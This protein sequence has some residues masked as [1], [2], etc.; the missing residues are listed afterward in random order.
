MTCNCEI[1]S[2][3]EKITIP[4]E[5]QVAN[6]KILSAEGISTVHLSNG[7]ILYN[8][9]Y[10]P[11][12]NA[13]LLALGELQ[14]YGVIYQNNEQTFTLQ[15]DNSSLIISKTHGIYPLT[16]SPVAPQ[17][18]HSTSQAIKKKVKKPE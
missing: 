13:N 6:N 12:L 14:D 17:D 18:E 15:V 7:I 9:R 3:F 4:D 16:A 11:T 2:N 1:F 8:V 5:I 10:F